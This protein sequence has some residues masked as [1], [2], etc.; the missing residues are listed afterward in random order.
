MKGY[1]ELTCILAVKNLCD[2]MVCTQTHVHDSN[3]V[4]LIS[5]QYP[6]CRLM[7]VPVDLTGCSVRNW[8]V[9]IC[10]CKK[11]QKV[12]MYGVPK[13]L[14]VFQPEIIKIYYSGLNFVFDFL[15][16]SIICACSLHTWHV[17][18]CLLQVFYFLLQSAWMPFVPVQ[19]PFQPLD[20]YQAL[21]LLLQLQIYLH[22]FMKVKLQGYP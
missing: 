6:F 8:S 21:L 3:D 18:L 1:N 12:I 2:H 15:Q 10:T 11:W 20:M 7:V 14:F 5:V 22:V 17:Y 19:L 9:P 16:N 4:A 13:H